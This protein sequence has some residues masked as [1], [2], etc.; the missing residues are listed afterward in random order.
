MS[1]S[2][3]IES[4]TNIHHRDMNHSNGTAMSGCVQYVEYKLGKT[5]GS[6]DN[7]R[8]YYFV[9]KIE[10]PEPSD[11]ATMIPLADVTEANCITWAKAA[12]GEAWLTA[13]KE[14]IDKILDEMVNPYTVTS[15][16]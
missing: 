16:E 4:V 7:M 11:P 6:G 5:H 14:R 13:E 10:I 2:D 9:D 1:Y 3:Y 15:F 12:K 8:S